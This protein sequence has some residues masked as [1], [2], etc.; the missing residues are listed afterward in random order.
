MKMLIG[1]TMVF[2]FGYL[3]HQSTRE[4]ALILMWSLIGMAGSF[5]LKELETS[6]RLLERKLAHVKATGAA[7]LVTA[8]PGCHLQLA[9]GV[10]DLGMKQPVWHVV[11]LLGRSLST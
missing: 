7:A 5:A 6:R 9:W 3:Q 10:R 1:L 4:V 11:E 8:N 2:Y